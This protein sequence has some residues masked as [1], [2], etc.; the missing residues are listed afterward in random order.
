[1]LRPVACS[2]TVPTTHPLSKRLGGVTPP[3]QIPNG[4]ALLT[5]SLRG[6][7][8]ASGFAVDSAGTGI[9]RYRTV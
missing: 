5:Q 6:N 8:L 7:P 9:V 4:V 2:P 3:G 1:M